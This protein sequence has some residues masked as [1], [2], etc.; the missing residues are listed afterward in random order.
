MAG[1]R[2]E[3]LADLEAWTSD[4]LSRKVYWLVGMAGM[5]K[6]TILHTRCEI[7]DG[8]KNMLGGSFFCSRG[9]KNVR[10]HVASSYDRLLTGQYITLV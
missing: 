2:I 6:S 10:T 4:D 1:T 5:G 3:I 9:S 7:L 8:K